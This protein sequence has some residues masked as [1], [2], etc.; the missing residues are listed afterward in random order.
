MQ[1]IVREYFAALISYIH[2]YTN[3]IT[4][5]N[6]LANSAITMSLLGAIVYACRKVPATIWRFML[7]KFTDQYTFTVT[8]ASGMDKR[9]FD[10]V[11]ELVQQRNFRRRVYSLSIFNDREG[12]GMRVGSGK[13]TGFFFLYGGLVIY[14]R[15]E[16]ISRESCEFTFYF[17]TFLVKKEKFCEFVSEDAERGKPVLYR[18]HFSIYESPVAISTFDKNTRFNLNPA[19]KDQIDRVLR[20]QIEQRELFS[21]RRISNKLNFLFVGPPGTGKTSLAMYIAVKTSRSILSVSNLTALQQP[22]NEVFI[23]RVNPVVVLDD[24]ERDDIFQKGSS[25]TGGN[26]ELKADIRFMLD[27]LDGSRVTQDRIVVMTCND[28]TKLPDAFYRDN[29]VDAL[30]HIDYERKEDFERCLK[31]YF[32]EEDASKY[33]IP[34]D[35]LF[36]NAMCANLFKIYYNDPRKWVQGL[37]EGSTKLKSTIART[38]EQLV[39]T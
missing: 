12:R 18:P 34:D 29:R 20:S 3:I 17:R 26:G 15:T 39:E 14:T 16:N 27:F 4:N 32:P 7:A 31:F 25:N 19:V 38:S 1:E 28:I 8:S 9:H 13:G 37:I 22:S 11:A 35:I 2:S 10:H 24:V 23:S 36:S 30:I 21:E 6:E 5:G 33:S